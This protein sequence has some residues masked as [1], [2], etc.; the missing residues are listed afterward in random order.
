MCIIS[1]IYSFLPW[2]VAKCNHVE[3]Y[4]LLKY[5]LYH[6]PVLSGILHGESS[7]GSESFV[8]VEPLEVYISRLWV[9]KQQ[10]IHL[11]VI[12]DIFQ[13]PKRQATVLYLQKKIGK[14]LYSI[15]KLEDV[16]DG[17]VWKIVHFE[18]LKSHSGKHMNEAKHWPEARNLNIAI[19]C[20]G[21]RDLSFNISTGYSSIHELDSLK[22]TGFSKFFTTS[23]LVYFSCASPTGI[24]IGNVCY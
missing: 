19:H 18:L 5:N 11:W 16:R 12:L 10:R 3:R 22:H 2:E 4:C 1:K 8:S 7:R 13:T 23:N 15:L 21:T 14:G 24:K 20:L 6:R 17:Y 9:T